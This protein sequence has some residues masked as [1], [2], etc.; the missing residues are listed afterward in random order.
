[1]SGIIWCVCDW[2]FCLWKNGGGEIVEIF[3][4][5]EN[6][7]FDVF[8]W[9]ISMVWVVFLGLFL[10]FLG[11]DCVLIVFEGGVMILYLLDGQMVLQLGLDFLVFLGDVFCYVDLYDMVLLD[12][13]VMVCCLFVVCVI[14][15]VSY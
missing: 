7:G 6:V 3:C 13:N 9:W 1:M 11:V 4:Y 10:V 5:L 12:L 2:Q 8:Q 14:F 15:V